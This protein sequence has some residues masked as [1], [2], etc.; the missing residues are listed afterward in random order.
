MS[1]VAKKPIVLPSGVEA[2]LSGQTITI[3]GSKGSVQREIHFAV[4]LEREGNTIKLSPKQEG[5]IK[6]SD[7]IAGTTRALLYNMVIGVTQGFERKLTLIGVGYRAQAQGNVLSL[8]L[9]FSHPVKYNVPNGITIETP[10]Q[11]EIVVKGI[12]KQAVG[13]VAAD[14]R[15]FRPP[16]PYKGKGVRYADEII[17][18]KEGKKK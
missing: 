14:I 12:D 2:T 7:A 3:K 11:T 13:Q 8:T 16:E 5:D 10:S 9:G 15:A 18:L 17:H 6:A 4:N 1:R